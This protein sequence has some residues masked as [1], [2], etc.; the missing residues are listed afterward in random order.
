MGGEG[1]AVHIHAH[2]AQI[3]VH[4]HLGDLL[5]P[6]HVPAPAQVD[7]GL[8]APRRLVEVKRVLSGFAVKGHQSLLVFA[9]LAALVPAVGSKVE[10]VPH[11]GGPQPRPR[12][13]E[14][15]NVLVVDALV[16]FGVV[17]P[18]RGGGLELR[19][20]VRTVLGEAH[21]AVG[22]LGVVGVKEFVI[23]LQAAQ[24]PPE[25][26]VVAVHVRDIQNGA[27]RLQHEH[28]GHGGGSG[29]VEA[30]AQLVQ[31]PVVVQHILRHRAAGGD[32]V[33]QAPH[34]D[35]RMVITLGHQLPHLGQGVLTPALHVLGDVGD[36]R[37]HHEAV[38]IAQVVKLLGVLV[39]GQP[40]GVGADLPDERHI[41]PVLSQGD[42]I[43]QPLAVLVPGHATEGIGAPIEEEPFLRVDLELPAAEPGGDLV[44]A[45]QLGGGGVEMRVVQPIP[46]PDV[47]NDKLRLGMTVHRG[48][49]FGLAVDGEGHRTAV[50]PRL[51]RDGGGF[52]L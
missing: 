43:A 17:A 7:E 25:I 10:Q 9:L 37:P 27:V 14:L 36:L 30:V 11:M 42:G 16:L 19:V 15:Q 38:F 47:F 39:V 3:G 52:P 35:G 44:P 32:L 5:R 48:D 49:G 22:I 26:Q 50:L 29:G 18:L 28:I 1:L 23:L 21:G 4:L 45:V 12:L 8:T 6:V 2:R 51:H 40:D 31:R 33:T 46:Q 13:D 41:L 34:R 24:I 20:G